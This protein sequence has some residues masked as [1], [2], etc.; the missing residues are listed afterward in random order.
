MDDGGKGKIVDVK[1]DWKNGAHW[2]KRDN[3]WAAEGYFPYEVPGIKITADVPLWYMTRLVEA[4]GMNMSKLPANWLDSVRLTQDKE[5]I[6]G[7]RINSPIRIPEGTLYL[8]INVHGKPGG[9]PPA[10]LRTPEE[11]DAI[12]DADPEIAEWAETL[13]H[14]HRI[15]RVWL[16]VKNKRFREDPKKNAAWTFQY[17]TVV[18]R[19][20]SKARRVTD[21]KYH[22][23]LSHLDIVYRK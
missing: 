21:H 4:T 20:H 22:R 15:P 19:A 2:K 10:S 18:A 1:V 11:V 16:D 9:E 3:M 23:Q 6:G 14:H 13:I 12:L 7:S 8:L 5:Y 17:D